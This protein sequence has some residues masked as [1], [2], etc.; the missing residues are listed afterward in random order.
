MLQNS[1]EKNLIRKKLLAKRTDRIQ[2]FYSTVYQTK[3][4]IILQKAIDI[5]SAFKPTNGINSQNSIGL[6]WPLP[7]E[8]DLLKLIP[9]TQTQVS[10]PKIIHSV[11]STYMEF[12]KY[13]I[14]DPISQYHAKFNTD[15]LKVSNLYQPTS[16]L[17]TVPSIIFVPGIAFSITGHRLGFGKGF[18]DRYTTSARKTNNIITIG[19]TFNEF[20]FETLPFAHHDAKMDYILTEDVLIKIV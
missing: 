6:Y 20:L 2:D 5:V 13:N 10:L 9:I 8:V 12:I 1:K 3:N 19:V 7:F 15:T 16:N 17:A 4:D 11:D 18:Y 14:G